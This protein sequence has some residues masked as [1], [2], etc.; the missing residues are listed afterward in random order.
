MQNS[1]FAQV[2]VR[3]ENAPAEQHLSIIQEY[4][5]Q[6]LDPEQRAIAESVFF[7]G[8][9][10]PS[11]QPQK[12]IVVL[13]HGILTHAVWQ[14]RLAQRLTTEADIEAFPI[15]YGFLDVLRFWFPFLTRQGPINKVTRELRTLRTSY[16]NA[17]ISVVAHSFGTYI[18]AQILSEETDIQI[19]RLQLCGSIVPEKYRWDKVS[20]RISGKV[21]NDAGTRDYWPVMASLLSWGYGASG[22]FGFKTIPVKDR[23]FNCGHSDFFTDEHMVKYWVPLLIDGQVVPSDW[24]ISRPSPSILTSLLYWLPLKCIILIVVCI[25]LFST[26]F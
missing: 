4:T 18:M 10:N 14:E 7:L 19:N 26:L 9:A 22:T 17:K 12:N 24:N 25:W 16:P 20:S 1:T 15:G 3:L 6:I 13:I 23:F 21:I 8:Q 5:R 2:H 11:A